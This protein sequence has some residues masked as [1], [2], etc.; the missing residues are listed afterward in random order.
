MI[1]L[2][3]AWLWNRIVAGA[4]VGKS[5]PEGIAS[6]YSES[7]I[8]P[9]NLTTYIPP[10]I[11]FVEPDQKP[12]VAN[13]DTTW[14]LCSSIATKSLAS[15][16]PLPL[17]SFK[18]LFT[19]FS[20]FF[21]SFHHCT[22]SLSVSEQYLALAERHLPISSAFPN[23]ATLA[24]IYSSAM[25]QSLYGSVTLYSAPFPR[26]LKLCHYSANTAWPTILPKY[27]PKQIQGCAFPASLA[28]TKGIAVAF[29]SF[30]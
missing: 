11:R 30:A 23:W 14:L 19:L 13:E 29:F 22:C 6:L 26:D 17:I 28:V 12:L 9:S 5:Q 27:S 18:D 4:Q 20:K 8:Q 1:T 15:H 25:V 24:S 10:L 3:S 21:S 7:R 16:I 2:S